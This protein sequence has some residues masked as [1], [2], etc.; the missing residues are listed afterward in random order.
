[1]QL[2]TKTTRRQ[3]GRLSEKS[4]DP[5]KVPHSQRRTEAIG[6]AAF[7]QQDKLRLCDNQSFVESCLALK[8]GDLGD[9]VEQAPQLRA[10]G[11]YK[12]R[13]PWTSK[14]GGFRTPFTKPTATNRHRKP[15]T[16]FQFR[17]SARILSGC[18]KLSLPF[19]CRGA[20]TGDRTTAVTGQ[21]ASVICRSFCPSTSTPPHH[22]SP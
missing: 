6:L 12:N 16:L 15:H 13:K 19:S 11:R 5:V 10:T 17:V 18:S 8:R 22:Y 3:R 4:N 9:R 20:L 14:Q 2:R 7:S 21:A 1:M